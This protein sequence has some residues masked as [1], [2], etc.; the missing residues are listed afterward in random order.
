MLNS[1]E[2]IMGGFLAPGLLNFGIEC[3]GLGVEM[4]SG[5]RYKGPTS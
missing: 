2:L 3:I 4:H 5:E 1:S